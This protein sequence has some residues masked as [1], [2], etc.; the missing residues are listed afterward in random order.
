MKYGFKDKNI[1]II[2]E[3]IDMEP[4]PDLQA[5][6]KYDSPTI[7]AFGSARPMKRINHVRKAFEIAKK[8][9]PNLQLII[10]DQ[11][12]ENKKV[13]LMQKSHLM[14]SASVKEGW[15]LIVTE[16][17]SQ[18]TPAVAYNVDGLA[19]SIIHNKTGLL[20][21]KNTPQNLA[22]NIITLLQDSIRYETLRRNAW[23][24]SKQITFEKSYQDFKKILTL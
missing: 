11:V 15:G 16:A 2:S 20:C 13:E 1:H 18:G 8:E 23:T 5:V 22:E 4:V 24:H 10:A 21:S 17:N 3:G 14:C 12:D 19:D 7:L 9:I 6:Q